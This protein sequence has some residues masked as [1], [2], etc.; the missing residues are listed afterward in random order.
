METCKVWNMGM[1][2]VQGMFRGL[3]QLQRHSTVSKQDIEEVPLQRDAPMINNT[4][5]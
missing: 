1:A 4:R 5:H 3:E 2:T